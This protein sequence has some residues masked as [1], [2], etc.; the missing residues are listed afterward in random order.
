MKTLAMAGDDRDR[1]IRLAAFTFLRD[2]VDRHG[3]VLP[4][5]LLRTG[6]LFQDQRSHCRLAKLTA[7]PRKQKVPSEADHSR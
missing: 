3:E 6:F 2:Q 5:G 4:A 7:S 1:L